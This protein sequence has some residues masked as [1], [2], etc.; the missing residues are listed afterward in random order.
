MKNLSFS[1]LLQLLKK[2]NSEKHQDTQLTAKVLN[3]IFRRYSG[4]FL[5]FCRLQPQNM[6]KRGETIYDLHQE[7]MIK[8]FTLLKKGTFND[9]QYSKEKLETRFFSWSGRIIQNFFVDW[10]R[11]NE[12]RLKG[13]M[14]IWDGI[15]NIFSAFETDLTEEEKQ[16]ILSEIYWAIDN[17]LS[18]REK[19]ILENTL[20]LKPKSAPQE[21]LNEIMIIYKI[22]AE[23]N[24]WKTKN[25]ALQKIREHIE[26][27]IGKII[28]SF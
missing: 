14:S 21:V 18:V 25:N 19:F 13:T 15:E 4:K 5:H 20:F 27:K 2:S 17:L 16:K 8:I 1:D 22:S 10:Y 9:E 11:K 12:K 24:L 7:V 28:L 26:N 6:L 23:Y 3:E